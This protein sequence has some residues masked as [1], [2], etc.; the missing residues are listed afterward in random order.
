VLSTGRHPQSKYF[1]R[2]V[3]WPLVHKHT[4]ERQKKRQ[5]PEAIE[6]RQQAA[7][8]ERAAR[9]G[10]AADSSQ[11]SSASNAAEGGVTEAPSAFSGLSVGDG[12]QSVSFG[13][14]E[15]EGAVAGEVGLGR[16]VALYCRSSTSSHIF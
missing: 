16:I 8:A 12:S 6:V 11:G 4:Y 2:L 7:A 13:E 14:V 1:D 15:A 9:V 5:T 3:M 10:S